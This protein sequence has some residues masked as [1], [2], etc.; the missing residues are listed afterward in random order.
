M[1]G[2]TKDETCFPSPQPIVK[3]RLPI[4]KKAVGNIFLY[5]LELM[6]LI[7]YYH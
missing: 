7:C 5:R 4:K 3:T 1:E 6:P 2:H